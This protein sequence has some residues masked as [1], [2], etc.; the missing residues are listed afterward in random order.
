[1][2]VLNYSFNYGAGR[3]LVYFSIKTSHGAPVKLIKLH[4]VC[5][6]FWSDTSRSVKTSSHLISYKNVN[7]CIHAIPIKTSPALPL[8]NRTRKVTSASLL[9]GRATSKREALRDTQIKTCD[10]REESDAG[11]NIHRFHMSGE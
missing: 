11:R 9:D 6:L 5:R 10:G 1:M 7:K 4:C 8:W 2:S 3:P